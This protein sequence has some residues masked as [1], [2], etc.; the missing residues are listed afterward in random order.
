MPKY[1]VVGTYSSG[2]WARLMRSMDDRIEAVR[3][4]A[5]SLGGS[6]DCIYW[7]I[8]TRSAYAIVNEP[9]SVTVAAAAATMMQTG[10]FKSVDFHELLTQ[11]QLSD[12]LTVAKDVSQVYQVPGH[13][14][15]L[16]SFTHAFHATAPTFHATAPTLNATAPTFH[17]AAPT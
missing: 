15:G 14:A 2:T 10:A 5:E 9:D 17:A 8:G 1:L 6:L 11:D 7:E 3:K 16:A 4:F 12:A 13:T